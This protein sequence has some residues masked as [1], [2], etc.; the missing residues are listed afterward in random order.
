[1]QAGLNFYRKLCLMAL[2]MDSNTVKWFCAKRMERLIL[3]CGTKRNNL[4]QGLGIGPAQWNF[5]NKSI[6]STEHFTI[7][8]SVITE[9]TDFR[10]REIEKIHTNRHS[11]PI[12]LIFSRK[13]KKKKKCWKQN[14]WKFWIRHYWWDLWTGIFLHT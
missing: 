4:E 7:T 6:I 3:W 12:L 11:S 10:L 5:W 2:Y 8:I 13:I 1:M 14:N 9:D